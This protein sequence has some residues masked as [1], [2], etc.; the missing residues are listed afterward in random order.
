MGLVLEQIVP[1]GRSF[2]EYVP[3]FDLGS[4]DLKSRILSCG[5]GPASFNCE[6]NQRGHA[7]VSIDP[8][9]QFDA[10]QIEQRIGESY[11]EVIE[12]VSRNKDDFVWDTV[13]SV[14][15][16]GRIRLAAMREF[17]ADYE[18]GKKEKRYLAESL[19]SLSFTENRFDLALCSHFLFLYSG[20]LSLEF[21][22]E[23][24]LEMLRVANEVRIFPL[25]DL[26]GRP[27]SCLDG[28]TGQL[29]EADYEVEIRKV[30]YEFQRGGNEM[31]CIKKPG[32][33]IKPVQ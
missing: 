7:V 23:A 20:Q 32:I 30:S 9:Y 13:P 17:L 21:H 33:A 25:L 22:H 15:A 27:S 18:N 28:I 4:E 16:L 11:D 3:M 31:M 8:L 1:W 29:Q 6:M 5:D 19:P 24:I 10:G 2:A 14:D 26:D 12:Q